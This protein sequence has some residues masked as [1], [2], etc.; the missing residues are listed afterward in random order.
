MN[1]HH[2]PPKT[3]HPKKNLGRIHVYTGE[4]KGKTTASLGLALRALGHGY[5]ILVVQW[6]KGDK[7]L[8]EFKLQQY[9]PQTLAKN[10]RV[11]QFARPEMINLEAPQD[12]DVYLAQQGLDYVRRQMI[13][14]R[15]DVLILDE[16]NSAMHYGLLPVQEV[17]D[18][19]DNK[20]AETEVVLTGRKA[21]AEILN[22]AD[23]V[24]VMELVK[25]YYQRKFPA[26]HGIEF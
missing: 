26:R 17:L 2:K 19:L 8:G 13:E 16:I 20:H 15:P 18:F 11:V 21:P 1:Q 4:G 7:D 22:K 10:F 9:L 3:H 25:H 5:S 14:N 6:L 24:T 12:M 23:L